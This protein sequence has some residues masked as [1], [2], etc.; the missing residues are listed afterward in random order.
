MKT[1]FSLLVGLLNFDKVQGGVD[2]A[3]DFLKAFVADVVSKLPPGA[4][5]IA[6]AIVDALTELLGEYADRFDLKAIVVE[7][8]GTMTPEMLGRPDP[9]A[10]G[11]I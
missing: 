11:G 5:D 4:Q 6:G 9:K 3:L 2:D 7:L 1:L 10:G 8:L